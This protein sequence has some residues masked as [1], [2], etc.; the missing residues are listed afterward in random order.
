MRNC[1][2]ITPAAVSASAMERGEVSGG[3]MPTWTQSA[4][5]KPARV[6]AVRT[7]KLTL[8]PGGMSESNRMSPQSVPAESIAPHPSNTWR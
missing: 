4:A 2:G 1:A 8:V 7:R 5:S 3:V 6:S